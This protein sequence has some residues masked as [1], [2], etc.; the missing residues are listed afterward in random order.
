VEG[1]EEGRAFCIFHI[2]SFFLFF[3]LFLYTLRLLAAAFITEASMD[4]SAR[5][6]NSQ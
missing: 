3:S 2:S 4:Q 6:T 1:E 5:Q